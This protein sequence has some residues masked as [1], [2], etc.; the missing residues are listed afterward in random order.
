MEQVIYVVK[1]SN[2]AILM[3]ASE[4]K[5]NNNNININKNYHNCSKVTDLMIKTKGRGR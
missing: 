4:Y 5:N 1:Y 2:T 3:L